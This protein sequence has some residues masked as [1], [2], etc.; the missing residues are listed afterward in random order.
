MLASA[1]RTQIL[2]G[3]ATLAVATTSLAPT[4]PVSYNLALAQ[5]V[6]ETSVLTA[7]SVNVSASEHDFPYALGFRYLSETQRRACR[8]ML[9]CIEDRTYS[10]TISNI[11][12]DDLDHAFYAL[13]S[14]HPELYWLGSY[15]YQATG[16]GYTFWADTNGLTRQEMR[17][18]Q[19]KLDAVADG[20][21]N[22][23]PEGASAA[24]KVRAAYEWVACN[25]TYDAAAVATQNLTA[26]LIDHRSVCAGY[27]AAFTFLCHKAHVAATTVSGEVTSK[28]YKHSWN[29][30]EVDGKPT[31]VDVTFGDVDAIGGDASAAANLN[32]SYLGLT[33]DEIGRDRTIKYANS[34]PVCTDRSL[35]AYANATFDAYRPADVTHLI[36]AAL[37]RGKR[38]VGFEL[39]SVSAFEQ[40]QAALN[41]G[42][43]N[44]FALTG[45]K[46]RAYYTKELRLVRITW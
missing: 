41:S 4:N 36:A 6:Y 14:D 2:K 16:D 25:T 30:V 3:L 26:S 34:L 46:P 5:N 20:F 31:Y 22:T 33:T 9:S 27:S 10:T 13:R 19:K 28:G 12:F 17:D 32:Y 39:G 35:N 24:D 29:L 21:L 38:Q 23:L 1:T 18:T 40:A 15:H 11:S 8:Q 42:T 7:A 37:A 45:G 43:L 44:V